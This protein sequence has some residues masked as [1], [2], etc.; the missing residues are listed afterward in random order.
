MERSGFFSP[1]P[2]LSLLSD[3]ELG[4]L[5]RCFI[6]DLMNM[7]NKSQ[8]RISNYLLEVFFQSGLVWG[9]GCGFR[10]SSFS[11]FWVI[12]AKA[13]K[14]YL[15]KYHFLV[16]LVNH[17]LTR[18]EDKYIAWHRLVCQPVS[19]RV[20]GYVT[21]GRRKS[22]FTLELRPDLKLRK[23]TTNEHR[24]SRIQ[25]LLKKSRAGL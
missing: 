10:I 15:P 1:P 23:N 12:T 22:G 25:F 20:D 13:K 18:G 4:S 16:Y 7:Q 2:I 9:T 6:V 8:R 3:K 17:W 5:C 11:S 21:F 19:E 14:L 24:L